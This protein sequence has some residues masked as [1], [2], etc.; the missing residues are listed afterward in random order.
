[1]EYDE[2]TFW[3][4]CPRFEGTG[5]ADLMAA[6]SRQGHSPRIFP[7]ATRPDRRP[8]LSRSCGQGLD[9]S[10]WSSRDLARQAVADGIAPAISDREV[11]R[12]PQLRRSAT[13]PDAVLEDSPPRLSARGASREGPLV[14]RQRR[15][16]GWPKHLVR[17]RR[18]DPQ[19]PGLGAGPDPAGG[20]RG[21]R[22]AGV[23]VRPPRTVNILVLL[24]VLTGRMEAASL[25]RNDA[26][27]YIEA[28]DG[29]RRRHRPRGVNLVQVRGS[30]SLSEI[31]DPHH[32]GRGI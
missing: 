31:P 17:L 3:R 1:M 21:H 12:I 8:G 20:P 25:A 16:V 9:I 22:A 23:R 13:A 27:H 4:F 18:R 30:R 15:P 11:R 5:L 7:P 14:L 6:P 2:A 32:D 10:H 19:L 24:V 29:F 26:G 28:L